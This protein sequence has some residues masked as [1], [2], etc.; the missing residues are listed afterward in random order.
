M[1]WRRRR[2]ITGA[3][4]VTNPKRNRLA[5]IGHDRTKSR[6]E[7]TKAVGVS[8]R[9]VERASSVRGRGIPKL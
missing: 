6:E 8:P 1:G 3:K 9:Q 2:A 4:S 5:P 7:A